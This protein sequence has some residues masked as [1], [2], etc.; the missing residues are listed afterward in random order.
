MDLVT[1][2]VGLY[3]V[4]S[5]AGGLI[6]YVKAKSTASLIAGSLAGIVLLVCAVGIARGS[7]TAALGSAVVALL[8]GGRFVGTWIRRRRVMPDLLMVG[9][10]LAV[11]IAVGVRLL[12]P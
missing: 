6:G 4:I 11:L 9:G 12:M 8:L 3:G 10:A 7:H 2:V 1:S 5:L